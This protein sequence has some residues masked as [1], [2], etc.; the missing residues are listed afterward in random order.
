MNTA[1]RARRTLA[2]AAVAAALAACA[3]GSRYPARPAPETLPQGSPLA[4]QTLGE[5]DAWLRHYVMSGAADSAVE[6]LHGRGAPRD[7][8]V[9]HLQL[10]VA[11]HQ[12]GKYE[13]SNQAL[14]WADDEAERRYTQ[15]LSQTAAALL[16]ND[17]SIAYLPPTAERAMVPYYR[18]LNHLALGQAEGAAVEARRAGAFFARLR[19][20]GAADPCAGE[21]LVQYVA[22]LS[23]GRA[24]AHND[25]LVSF[26]Q[27]ERAFDECEGAAA[28]PDLGEWL[29]RSAVRTGVPQVADSA[30]ARYRLS[31]AAADSAA[32]EL[33]VLVEHGWVA[34]RGH[35]D[36][37]VPI[38]AE[39]A[40]SL[41]E[42]DPEALANVL[43]HTAVNLADQAQWGEAWEEN[44]LQQVADALDGAYI[45]K[46]SWP[47]YR[48]ESC[49][50]PDVR[51]VVGGQAVDA[52]VTGDLSAAMLTRWEQARRAALMRMVVRGA[53]KFMLTRAVEA[54]GEKQGGEAVGWIL[55][56]L[57]NL[58][59][60]QMERADTRSWSL[61][62]D[63]VSV[64]RMTLAPGEHPVRI[65]VTRADGEPVWVDL[66]TVTVR[67]GETLVLNRR[68]WG[69]EMGDLA[70][71][72]PEMRQHLAQR[73]AAPT[74][75]ASAARAPG[76][77]AIQD[78]GA[79]SAA[80]VEVAT[81]P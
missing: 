78:A 68:V 12:A 28:P 72:S 48:L 64:A 25:A 61:L 37:H 47:V 56:R 4:S 63:R 73:R 9:R 7:P 8:L 6:M 54:K 2:F 80:P 15:S 17:A 55:G 34:H 3:P 24:G 57:S 16:V 22:G 52:P 41:A 38:F 79:K 81:Q 66:G 67:A 69:S 36:I 77:A 5:G 58:A 18:M 71:R 50:A 30:A 39:E 70:A 27:A 60:N 23:F 51:L 53:G 33:V 20:A 11:L 42:G 35:A 45:M 65:E 59:S 10:A 74:D 44:A 19:D 76:A 40:D 21:G 46:L 43:I 75:T 26:R 31:T 49:S 62:P 14:A 13:E 1:R 29:Y 32:G